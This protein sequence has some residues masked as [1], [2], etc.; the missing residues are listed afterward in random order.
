MSSQF[1]EVWRQKA[2]ASQTT[3]LT[4]ILLS[5]ASH[6]GRRD[7]A[8]MP[9]NFS[10]FI[11]VR[12]PLNHIIKFVTHFANLCYIDHRPAT[13]NWLSAGNWTERR[14]RTSTNPTLHPR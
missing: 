8:P 7:G 5:N 6:E 11:A 14:E 12:T 2:S 4:N 10:L 1:I 9:V 3:K 13:W